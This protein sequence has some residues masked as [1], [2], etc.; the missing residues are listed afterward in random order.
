[1]TPLLGGPDTSKLTTTGLM[2]HCLQAPVVLGGEML[3]TPTG[4]A[5]TV[6]LANRKFR[7]NIERTQR[8]ERVSTE[9]GLGVSIHVQAA[10][11]GLPFRR[12]A[13]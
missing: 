5:K 11:R 3:L 2:P 9:G 4:L 12:P 13:Y 8:F 10:S 7:L 6:E 1:M